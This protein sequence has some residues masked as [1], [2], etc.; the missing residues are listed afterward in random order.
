MARPVRIEYPGA[1]YHVISRGNER[2][3]VFRGDD[4]YK[5]F[6]STLEEASDRFDVLIHAYCLMPNRLHLLIQTKDSN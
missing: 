3:A 1:F 4:D 5:L 2:R 6:L